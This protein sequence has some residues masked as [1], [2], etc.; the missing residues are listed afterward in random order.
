VVEKIIPTDEF[1]AF[2]SEVEL[3]T[4]K[5]LPQ[6]YVC[7]AGLTVDVRSAT[8]DD[9]PRLYSI[10]KHVTDTGQGYGLDEFPT[11]NAFRAM[12]ADVYMVVVEELSSN[13]VR[14]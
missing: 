8:K 5:F 6:I 1:S 3:P 10:M 12:T 4:V 9:M 2:Y 11:Y 7:E 13:K 14:L